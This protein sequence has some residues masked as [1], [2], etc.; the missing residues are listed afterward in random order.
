MFPASWSNEKIMQAVSEVVVN[1]T[2]VQQTCRAGALVT[3][4]GYPVRFVVEGF[5][6]GVKI[7][8]VTTHT[9]I[10]TAYPIR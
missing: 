10:I 1:N 5:Y 4:S 9:E 6:Q 2:W 8:V 7:K 3:R